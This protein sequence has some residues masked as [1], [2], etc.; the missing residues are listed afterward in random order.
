MT[1][2]TLADVAREAYSKANRDLYDPLKL[3]DDDAAEQRWTDAWQAAAEAVVME[4][5]SDVGHWLDFWPQHRA[6]IEA[7]KALP[8]IPVGRLPFIARVPFRKFRRAVEALLVA[9]GGDVLA[10]SSDCKTTTTTPEDE[11]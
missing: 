1:D 11:Q 7:A 8:P 4:W 3:Y 6:V 9:E 10:N 5:M 2:K